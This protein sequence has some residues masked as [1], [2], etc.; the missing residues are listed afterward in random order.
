[1]TDTIHLALP[2]IEAAQAQKHVTHNEALQALDALAQLSVIAR[3]VNTPP[4]APAEGARY[5][6]GASPTGAFAGH[7]KAVASWLDGV[8]R[9]FPPRPGWLAYV[10]ADGASKLYDGAQWRD[11]ASF[12]NIPLLGVG[13]TADAANPLAAKLNSTL[14]TAKS[15]AEGGTGD[16]RFNL[17]KSAAGNLASQLDRKSTRLN[18]SH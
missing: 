2:F 3:D 9:F 13:T 18:S 12:N 14:F 8:W 1:M 5:I 7:A 10:E 4:A 6:V 17:N 16:L 15:V 11:A